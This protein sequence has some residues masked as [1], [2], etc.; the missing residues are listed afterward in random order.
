MA[1]ND[2]NQQETAT[3]TVDG[4]PA[5]DDKID[6]SHPDP[7]RE[8]ALRTLSTMDQGGSEQQPVKKDD[9]DKDLQYVD[10]K[11][12]AIFANAR[13]ARSEQQAG[14]DDPN[15]AAALYGS[16]VVV[17]AQ[18]QHQEQPK[19][20]DELLT[21]K[22]KLK[23]NGKESEATVAELIANAQ[24]VQAGDQYLQNAKQM[25][26]QII[27]SAAAITAKGPKSTQADAVEDKVEGEDDA[28][29]DKPDKTSTPKG[30]KLDRAKLAKAVEAIS[31]NSTDEGVEALEDVLKDVAQPQQPTDISAAVENVLDRREMFKQ[32]VDAT[33]A[34]LQKFPDLA[35][36]PILK[37]VSGELLS[38]E[39]VKDFK[40]AGLTDAEIAQM[41]P[42][43][44][45]LKRAHDFARVKNPSF[46]RSL[47][48]HYQVIEKDERWVKL[49]GSAATPARVDIQVDQG[50][51]KVLVRPQP[52]LR[53]P[54]PQPNSQQ[55]QQPSRQAG[56]AKGFEQIRSGRA[57]QSTAG[58]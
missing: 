29:T 43:R 30:A 54:P 13:R 52:A 35:A 34:F 11:R 16:D 41:A 20:D 38:Q 48:Q 26:D 53:S 32:S 51:R 27:N 40:D 10:D 23:V 18:P 47:A 7:T 36:D 25:A 37:T 56:M 28:S 12:G 22:V 9:T 14:V 5:A 49:A 57:V 2:Q 6:N 55:L 31:L 3:P 24:K 1:Q 44:K 42:D 19:G 45:S 46:G 17:E 8:E 33:S 39:M 21:R 50:A 4:Q 58:A 15:Q